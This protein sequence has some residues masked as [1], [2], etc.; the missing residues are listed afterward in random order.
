MTENFKDKYHDKNGK[1]V[2]EGMNLRHDDGT[3]EKV[4]LSSDGDLGFNATNEK[5]VGWNGFTRELYP[6]HQFAI[7]REYEIVE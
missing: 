5:F 7:R 1:L 3:I 2:K 4:Y 6:L